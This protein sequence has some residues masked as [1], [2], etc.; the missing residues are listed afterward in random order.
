MVKDE[1]GKK[2]WVPIIA[3]KIF[4]EKELGESHLFETE[5]AVGRFVKVNLMTITNDIKHQNSNVKFQITESRDGRLFSKIVDY[6]VVPAAVKRLVRRRNDKI[7]DS[8]LAKTADGVVVRV[9]PLIITRGRATGSIRAELKKRLHEDLLRVVASMGIDTLFADIVFRKT[10]KT[11]KDKLSKVFPVRA[12]EIRVLSYAA[13]KQNVEIVVPAEEQ[14]KV[15]EEEPVAEEE[16]EE[17][18]KKRAKKT[19]KT[20]EEEIVIDEKFIEEKEEKP[21]RRSKKPE[22]VDTPAE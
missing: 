19:E 10:Q 18:I 12:L 6:E 5:E 2:K 15:P 8:F 11:L 7:D 20:E 1:K 17:S 14:V 16:V 9:K 21:K 22:T 3:P 13:G 4:N